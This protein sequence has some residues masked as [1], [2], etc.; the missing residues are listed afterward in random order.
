MWYGNLV[1]VVDTHGGLRVF[2]LDHMYRV[3]DSI[4][5]SMGKQSNGNYGAFGYK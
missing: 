1:Y 5:D 2:D 4:K 3:D